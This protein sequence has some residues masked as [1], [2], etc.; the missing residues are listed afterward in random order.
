LLAAASLALVAIFFG[1]DLLA[2]RGGPAEALA[3]GGSATITVVPFLALDGD[4]LS[5]TLGRTLTEEVLLEL[6]EHDL[7]VTAIE[8][9]AGGAATGT[10]ATPARYVLSGSVRSTEGRIRV[11][12]R[13]VAAS[14]G[15]QLWTAAYDES[16][17]LAT[18]PVEQ[19]RVVSA[20]GGVAAPYGPVFEAERLRVSV[21][22]AEELR[23][24]DCVLKYY[25]YRSSP[26]PASHAGALRCFQRATIAA[27]ELANSW[28]GLALMLLDVATFGYGSDSL[29][30][31]EVRPQAGEAARKAMDI[32]GTSLLANLAF[33]RVLFFV[34]DQFE[35]V[36]NRTLELYPNHLEALHIVGGMFVLAGD[37]ERG[38]AM[39]DRAITL[40][41]NPPGSYYAAQALGLVRL[42]DH[43]RAVT[44]ALRIDA[45]DW[46]MG[47]LIL[48]AAAGLAGRTDVAQRAYGRLR[49]LYPAIDEELPNVVRRFRAAP[50]LEA[51]LRRGLVAAGAE[52][53]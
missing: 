18:S 3:S 6:D 14:T 43:E 15:A 53:R 8:R 26:G 11:T 40:A 5:R 51:H 46:H 48:A 16:P 17:Q 50:D 28:A 49:E 13:L 30:V 35:R 2:P 23:T 52:L 24:S 47:Y 19:S 25:E 29:S 38:L 32:D 22:P 7:F 45:P 36:A 20:I 37:A 33:A 1:R 27:P 44:A 39:V 12:A 10:S 4:Q 9:A 34:D 41:P 42:G 31:A 21:L